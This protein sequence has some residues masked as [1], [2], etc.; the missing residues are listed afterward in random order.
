[1][2]ETATGSPCRLKSQFLFISFCFLQ[3]KFHRD[4][5]PVSSL[6]TVGGSAGSPKCG[7]LNSGVPAGEG[8][9]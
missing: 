8:P 1:M 3:A 4:Q 2:A 9:S 6:Q 7:G 5:E